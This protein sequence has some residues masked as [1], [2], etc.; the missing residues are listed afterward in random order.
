MWHMAFVLF[1][2]VGQV[3]LQPN[4]ITYDAAIS[5]RKKISE[6]GRG[7]QWPKALV[8]LVASRSLVHE[9]GVMSFTSAMSVCRKGSVWQMP[10]LLFAATGHAVLRP[11]TVAYNSTISACE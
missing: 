4:T 10:L 11:N 1:A 9:P 2:A 5:A 7:I 3:V 6:C 8:L